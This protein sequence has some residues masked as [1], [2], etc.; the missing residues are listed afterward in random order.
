MSTSPRRP[1]PPRQRTE[2]L[3]A[4]AGGAPTGARVT[5]AATARPPGEPPRRQSRDTS[6]QATARPNRY[7]QL[8]ENPVLRRPVE[9]GQ[10]TSVGMVHELHV[11]TGLAAREG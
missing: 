11:G 10:R 3:A 7:S 8:T 9:S 1:E 5:V 2:A 4:A 6:T